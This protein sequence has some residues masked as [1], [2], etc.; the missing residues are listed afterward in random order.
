MRKILCVLL[1]VLM[2][3]SALVACGGD[4]QD[5]L[6]IGLG[7]YTTASAADAGEANGKG[8][9]TMTVAAVLVDANGKIVQC[10]ID[11]ADNKVEFTADGKAVA[12]TEFKTKYE[13]G[14]GYGMVN[15]GGATKEWFEQAD[16]FEAL[17]V[18]KTA[19]EVL[20]L[21]VNGD[22][23][24]DEVLNAGCTITINEMALAVEKAVKNA[25]DST[26]TKA[27]TLKLG[28][29]TSLESKDATADAKGQQKLATTFVAVALNANG[30]V[31]G[32]DT[33]CVQVSFGFDVAGKSTFDASQA[34]LSKRELGAG[35]NMV[36]YGGAKLEW[37]EQAD[38]FEGAIVGK[39]LTAIK[40]LMGS[41]LK[42]NDEII[43]AGCTITIEGF[44][45]AI[46]KLG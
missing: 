42:G 3:A 8:Q 21:V 4:K 11:C 2:L 23:G 38:A 41:D 17:C 44:V 9:V 37:F 12:K 16:A 5:P 35:Y 40:A 14:A 19:A 26:A 45:Y 24:T 22:K 36:A 39:T 31:T 30:E 46:E 43:T 32:V 1:C 18:G 27:D 7:V 6:K 33:D 29:F 25:A 10:Q 28:A 15:Y 20:A 13:Q 34:V